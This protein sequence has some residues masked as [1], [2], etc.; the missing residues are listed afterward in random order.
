MDILEILKADYQRF[1]QDQTYGIYHPQVYFKDPLTEFR[2][3]ARYQQMIQFFQTWF[4]AVQ[5]DLHAIEQQQEQILTSWTLHWTTP[6]PWQPRIAI[7]GHSVLI[8]NDQNQII[9]HLDT[10]DISPWD[11]VRQH[12][13]SGKTR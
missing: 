8:L 9:S 6:L 13:F 5:L 2:G 10:W 7:P 12:F 11:V 1:P 3:L 4:K